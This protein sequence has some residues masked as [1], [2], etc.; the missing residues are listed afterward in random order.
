MDVMNPAVAAHSGLGKVNPA[1]KLAL[2]LLLTASFL[3]SADWLKANFEAHGATCELRPF[4]S[5]FA[6]NVIW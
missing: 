5:G 4:L 2:G 6:P 3:V 1:I